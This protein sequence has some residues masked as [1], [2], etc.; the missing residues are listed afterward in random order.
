MTLYYDISATVHRHAGLGR[1][2]DSLG[3]ALLDA[4]GESMAL[5][6]YGDTTARLPPGLED[7]PHRTAIAGR[8]R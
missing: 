4:H 3:R 8:K 6:Y 2:A 1:Y 5:F 7:V